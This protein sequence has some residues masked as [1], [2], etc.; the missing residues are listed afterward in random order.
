MDDERDVRSAGIVSFLASL[1]SLGTGL[2]FSVVVTRRLAVD[3]Y[4]IW[5]FYSVVVTYLVLPG[6]IVNFWLTRYLGR[7]KRALNTGLVL[8]LLLSTVTSLLLI[9]ASFA[10]SPLVEIGP[11]ELAA[12]LLYLIMLYLSGSIDAASI[13]AAPILQG[14]GMF[15][16][17]FVKVIVGA[18][19]VVWLRMGLLGA[20]LSIDIALLVKCLVIY[21]RMPKNLKGPVDIPSGLL[22]LKNWWVPAV[23]VLPSLIVPLDLV[24]LTW[25]TNSTTTAYLGLAKTI[26]AIASYPSLLA[27]PL[28]SSLLGGG[29]RR[30]VEDSM[31]LVMVFAFPM[32]AGIV[33]LALPIL[34]LFGQSYAPVVTSLQLLSAAAFFNVISGLA[35]SILQGTERVDVKERPLTAELVRS[36]LTIPRVVE[37]IAHGSYILVSLLVLVYVW[38]Q[39]PSAELAVTTISLI[40]LVVALLLSATLWT[41]S[42]RAHW[43]AVPWGDIAKCVFATA[44]MCAVVFIL[45]PIGAISARIGDVLAGLLPVIGVGVLVYF[46]VLLAIHGR[47]REDLTEL[48]RSWKGRKR[49][50]A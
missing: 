3:E 38:S 1:V 16:Q 23:A 22:W 13:G 4:G 19:L 21:A 41:L 40:N 48:Y 47:F 20:V 9:G 18:F 30:Q 28:Y 42:R 29:G 31:R 27:T 2:V 36:N 14:T 34:C 5:Q 46:G 25:V 44:V 8:N 6:S 24:V 37:I 7:G 35:M 49:V 50:N 12:L 45:Y 26:A 17:E 33:S 10:F 15:V 39:E 11:Y 43:F 32:A